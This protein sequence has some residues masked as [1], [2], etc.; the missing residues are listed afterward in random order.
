MPV[1]YELLWY[2]VNLE[3]PDEVRF[4]VAIRGVKFGSESVQPQGIDMTAPISEVGDGSG[5]FGPDDI[6]KWV[7]DNKGQIITKAKKPPQAG[8]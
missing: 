8:P 5:K 7:K 4:N 1:K 2:M 6:V 3:T